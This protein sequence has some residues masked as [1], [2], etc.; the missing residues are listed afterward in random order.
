MRDYLIR[1]NS[2]THGM[3]ST[4]QETDRMIAEAREATG[5]AIHDREGLARPEVAVEIL[6][7]AQKNM[8]ARIGA[9]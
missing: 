2:N 5:L 8:D 4:S 9:A 1:A 3:F 6:G 7:R